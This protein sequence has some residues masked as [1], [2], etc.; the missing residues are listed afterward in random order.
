MFDPQH[1][2]PTI[3]HDAKEIIRIATLQALAHGNLAEAEGI[4]KSRGNLV[5]RS[6][7]AVPARGHR[8]SLPAGSPPARAGL[9]DE[10]EPRTAL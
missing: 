1:K 4:T 9:V 5:Q 7:V 2:R 6:R 8:T 10:L 3:R